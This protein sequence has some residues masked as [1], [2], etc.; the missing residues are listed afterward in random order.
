MRGDN[1]TLPQSAVQK[2]KVRLLEQRLCWALRVRG[3]CDDNVKGI[4][5][6]CQELEP[7][8]NVNTDV[9]VVEAGGHPG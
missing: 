9:G 8:A 4:L 1:T 3:I 2:L 6:V 5:E 7:I